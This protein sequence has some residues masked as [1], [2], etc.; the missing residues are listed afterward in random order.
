MNICK[1]IKLLY[2]NDDYNTATYEI[3]T[4]G[5]N[6]DMLVVCATTNCLDDCSIPIWKDCMSTGESE[7]ICMSQMEEALVNLKKLYKEKEE[8][9]EEREYINDDINGMSMLVDTYHFIVNNFIAD[10]KEPKDMSEELAAEVSKYHQREIE[11]EDIRSFKTML[12]AEKLDNGDL[13][14]NG[15][16]YV[17]L[18]K[19]QYSSVPGGKWIYDKKFYPLDLAKE[20]KYKIK[21]NKY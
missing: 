1:T 14:I 9:G 13:I 19:E 10:V 2:R 17:E 12:F 11:F 6:S 20:R 3:T 16:V 21:R 4:E 18:A 8:K 15:N 5:D 7:V